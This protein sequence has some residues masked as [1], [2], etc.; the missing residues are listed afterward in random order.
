[1]RMVL[2]FSAVNEK[3][4]GMATKDPNFL[5]TVFVRFGKVSYSVNNNKNFWED[6]F[7]HLLKT[8]IFW[9][10]DFYDFFC[11][12]FGVFDFLF[13]FFQNVYKI[14]LVIY[15]L[16]IFR[17]P[18]TLFACEHRNAFRSRVTP[19]TLISQIDLSKILLLYL[20]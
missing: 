3:L 19:F 11:Y 1:M 9:L 6:H 16:V 14:F 15:P 2:K 8:V 4:S 20:D 5:N 13:V 10:F 17:D 12:Y 7:G 18:K